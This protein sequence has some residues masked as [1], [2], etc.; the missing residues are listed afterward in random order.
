MG[1]FEEFIDQ[2]SRFD[3]SPWPPGKP[4]CLDPFVSPRLLEKYKERRTHE[5]FYTCINLNVTL[6]TARQPL[7][8]RSLA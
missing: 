4:I 3:V 6:S 7:H 1:S 5:A 2:N 8:R